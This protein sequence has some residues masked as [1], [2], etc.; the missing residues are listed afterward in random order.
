MIINQIYSN[1]DNI[2]KTLTVVKDTN[3]NIFGGYI[4]NKHGIKLKHIRMIQIHFC[5]LLSIQTINRKKEKII[6]SEYAICC[7]SDN[8]PIF[9]D[10]HD[11]RIFPDSNIN[12]DSYSN[13]HSYELNN[14]LDGS[15]HFKNNY[16]DGN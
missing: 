16:L 3:N 10:G 14:Y 2:K 9:G 8:G 7:S 4:L 11:L 12:Q 15:K 13:K 5:F 1:C 6:E